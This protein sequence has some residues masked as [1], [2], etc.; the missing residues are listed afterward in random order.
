[1][2]RSSWATGFQ[3]NPLKIQR[4]SC[5]GA[6]NIWDDLAFTVSCQLDN[7]V[8]CSQEMK[9]QWASLHQT[10]LGEGQIEHSLQTNELHTLYACHSGKK[11]QEHHGQQSCGA[12]SS[13][14]APYP[15]SAA[16]TCKQSC[17]SLSVHAE[18][19][20]LLLT[21]PPVDPDLW[22]PTTALQAISDLRSK[23]TLERIFRTTYQNLHKT[24]TTTTYKCLNLHRSHLG[25]NPSGFVIQDCK[26]IF[27]L[28]WVIRWKVGRQ[29]M[30]QT[31]MFTVSNYLAT[32]TLNVW[33]LR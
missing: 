31:S 6:V 28:E 7:C 2:I 10:D 30:I 18:K 4:G 25:T 5:N 24:C 15:K 11:F 16:P 9:N 17:P 13:R 19:I 12:P 22:P 29:K 14:L 8:A 33:Q 1:M 20:N 32:F 21:L 26:P 3:C 27:L 23:I